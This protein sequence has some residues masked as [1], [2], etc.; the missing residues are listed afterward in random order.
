MPQLIGEWLEKLRTRPAIAFF[1]FFSGSITTLGAFSD[2]L[3]NIFT[4]LGDLA[5]RVQ[6]WSVARQYV[7]PGGGEF[8][9][10][11]HG[12]WIETTKAQPRRF[13]LQEFRKDRDYL[14]LYDSY[15]AKDND[16]TNPL[17]VRIP[18]RGGIAQRSYA[19]PIVW[20]DPFQ[21]CHD[22]C[23]GEPTTAP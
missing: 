7:R 4:I 5:D 3:S 6:F 22:V 23:R 12:Y 18:V 13:V 2:S 19:N 1:I 21:V 11:S 9:R 16:P 8:V 15:R 14:Y 20:T 17:L 10:L